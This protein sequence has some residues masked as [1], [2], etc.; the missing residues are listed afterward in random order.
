MINLLVAWQDPRNRRWHSIGKLTSNGR[1][2]VFAYTNGVRQAQQHGFT[3][4]PSF[5]AITSVYHADDLFPLFNNRL[6]SPARPDYPRFLEWLNVTD[7]Q[8][9]DP[10]LLL[11]ARSGGVRVTDNLQVFPYPERISGT[12]YLTRFLLHGLSHMPECSAERAL[13]LKVGERLYVMPDPQNPLDPEALAFRTSEIFPG[14]MFLVGYCPRFL[15]GDINKLMKDVKNQPILTVERVNLPPAPL[16]Y[17][18][19]CRLTMNW[20]SGFEPF[21]DSEYQPIVRSA[22]IDV[23]NDCDAFRGEEI[24]VRHPSS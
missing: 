21:S 5:P 18:V 22:E 8:N 19:L 2:Y 16:Q 9:A 23:Q 1:R 11:L 7:V 14:D 12:Q 15:R 13:S 17:R 6:L 3:S 4:L 20:P 24:G 10:R